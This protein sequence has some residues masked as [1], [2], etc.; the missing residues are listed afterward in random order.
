MNSSDLAR[1]KVALLTLSPHNTLTYYLKSPCIHN[2]AGHGLVSPMALVTT[3]R[4]MNGFRDC[5]DNEVRVTLNA[6]VITMTT[7]GRFLVIFFVALLQFV[8]TESTNQ[9]C[10]SKSGSYIKEEFKLQACARCYSF[11]TQSRD[12]TF[13]P[14]HPFLVVMNNQTKFPQWTIL[15]PDTE[16]ST[17]AE[18]ICRTTSTEMCFLWKKCCEDAVSCCERQLTLGAQENGTCPRTWDGYGCWDDTAPGTTVYI[19]CPSFLQYAISSRYAEKQCMDDGTWFVRGNN[20]KEQNF[21]WTDYTKC[22][23]KES[24]LVTVYLGLAC[25]VASIALLIPA[26]GIFLLYRSLRRQ[27]RIRLHINFFAALFMSDL[28]DILWDVLV[29]HDRLMTTDSN[30]SWQIQYVDACKVLAYLKIYFSC[31]TYVWMFCEGFYLHR[32][33]SNAFK[34]P[35]SLI[36]LYAI[37]WG[38]P[39]AYSGLYG[40][41]RLIYDNEICW[42]KSSGELQWII[43]APNLCCLIVNLFFLCNILRILLTQL[44]SHPN[45]PSNFRRALKATFVLIPLFG[46][47]LFVSIYRLPAGSSGGPE[48]EKFS[49]CVLNSQGFFVALIFCFFNGEVREESTKYN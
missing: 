48:Y 23:H 40:I 41:L 47:Q 14:S 44:Q 9:K 18:K 32:L 31:T 24:L 21:E 28:V 35:K 25:N 45:E 5:L 33:I 37:G 11:I 20:T 26:I 19:S 8:A 16:N 46:V 29:T 27:H 10:R 17:W 4:L 3:N 1:S 13:H 36:F 34:P 39:L 43:F 42:V 6:D 7:T 22:L 2:A 15:I 12:V 49:V 30:S 38:F